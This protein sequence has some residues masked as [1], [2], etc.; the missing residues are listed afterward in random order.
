MTSNLEVGAYI[1]INVN[2]SI[3]AKRRTEVAR[4]IVLS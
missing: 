3:F 2:F 1:T 4:T